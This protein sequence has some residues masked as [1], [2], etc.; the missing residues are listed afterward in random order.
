MLFSK[1]LF[2]FGKLGFLLCKLLLLGSNHI[3]V[4]FQMFLAAVDGILRYIQPVLFA[5]GQQ[6]FST[7]SIEADLSVIGLGWLI[8]RVR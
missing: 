8:V 2:F 6:K 7:C 1:L 3:V 4:L 5:D